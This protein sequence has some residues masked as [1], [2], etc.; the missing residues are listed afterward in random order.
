MKEDE[1][2]TKFSEDIVGNKKTVLFVG[3]GVNYSKHNP[4]T[5]PYL[6]K[7]LTDHAL[8]TMNATDEERQIVKQ[9][10]LG[11]PNNETVESLK[12]LRKADQLFPVEVKASIVKQLLGDAYI[13]FLK[14]FLYGIDAHDKKDTHQRLREG[15]QQYMEGKD[16]EETPFRSLIS[17][18]D[19]I[20]HHENIKAVVTYNYD[21]F[22]TCAINQLMSDT[23]FKPQGKRKAIN[24]LDIYSGWRDAPIKD[25]DFLIYHI[26]GMVPPDNKI[27]PHCSNQI[28]LSLE[29]FYDV[30]KNVYSWQSAVQIYFLTHYT[31]AFIGASLSDMTM[32]RVLHYANL[33]QSGENVYYLS[34]KLPYDNES[35][36]VLEKLK[37]SY[38]GLLGLKV[39]YDKDGYGKLYERL[40]SIK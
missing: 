5:W 10:F 35:E 38:F 11:D 28:V 23:N 40:N 18:A 32:Q 17:L 13:P 24:P 8:V 12:L 1:N 36:E 2:F 19:F 39:V 14:E 37:N 3:A 33:N 25:D 34:A 16:T 4:M 21:D 27:T 30:A 15:C 31:C 26:H 6:L 7:H 20:L 22:L 29:E 9:A